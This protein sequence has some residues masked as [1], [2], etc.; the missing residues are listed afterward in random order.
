MVTPDRFSTTYHDLYLQQF[1]SQ[2]QIDLDYF[3]QGNT[4][5]S[6]H[7]AN[8]THHELVRMEHRVY[9]GKPQKE[10]HEV[11][12]PASWWNAFKAEYP[13]LCRW[14][15]AVKYVTIKVFLGRSFGLSGDPLER[16]L[17]DY[18]YLEYAGD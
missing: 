9:C 12:Y 17:Q 8:Y 2:F 15:E 1:C 14:F 10:T 13:R 11:K 6:S 16:T 18:C 7:L 4:K 5:I 3:N